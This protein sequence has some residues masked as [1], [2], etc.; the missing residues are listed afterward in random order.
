MHKSAQC[1]FN[2]SMSKVRVNDAH[3]YFTYKTKSD[4]RVK[5]LNLTGTFQVVCNFHSQSK[6]GHHNRY[7][8]QDT[9]ISN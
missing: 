2:L 4:F 9:S 5:L 8:Y 6:R 7:F 1:Q 3:L